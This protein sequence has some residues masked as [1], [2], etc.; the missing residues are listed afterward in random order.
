MG[1]LKAA[2]IGLLAYLGIVVALILTPVLFLLMAA[3]GSCIFGAAFFFLL[4]MTVS[5]QPSTLHAAFYLLLWGAPAFVLAAIA[6][7]FQGQL[8]ARRAMRR[9]A[10]SGDVP[11]AATYR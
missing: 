2:A 4:W 3:V 10:L 7:H 1:V 5:H 8:K 6:G 11:F 9:A